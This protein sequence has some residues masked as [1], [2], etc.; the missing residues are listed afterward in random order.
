MKYGSCML[1][2]ALG[3][4]G[5]AVGCQGSGARVEAAPAPQKP[6]VPQTAPKTETPPTPKTRVDPL[7]PRV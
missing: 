3:V 7:H 6:T 2:V 4:V 5:L 1:W